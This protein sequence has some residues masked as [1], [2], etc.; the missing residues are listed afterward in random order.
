MSFGSPLRPKRHPSAG[1]KNA[2]WCTCWWSQA[3][4]KSLGKAQG[5][6]GKRLFMPLRIALTGNMHGPDVGEI[7]AL[8][9]AEDGDVAAP[10]AL[11]PLP[12]RMERL[13][14]WLAAHP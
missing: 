10:G 7:L 3:W 12:Q 6:K 14:A 5:R 1:N 2:D 13:R 9:A 4:I 8:L 11:V